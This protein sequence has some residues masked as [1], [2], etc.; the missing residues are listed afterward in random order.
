M[1][2][3]VSDSSLEVGVRLVLGLLVGALLH[4]AFSPAASAWP[5]PKGAHASV[6]GPPQEDGPIVVNARFELRDLND[7]DDAAERFEFGGTLELTWQ[8]ER[9]AFDPAVAGVDEKVYQGFFQFNEISPAWYPQIVLV[10]ESGMFE[11]HGIVLKVAPDGT[12]RLVQIVDAAAESDL[13]LRRYPFDEHRLEATFEVLDSSPAEVLL[14]TDQPREG[15]E[16]HGV[17]IPQWEVREITAAAANDGGQST[18]VLSIDA[19]RNPF[20]VVRLVVIPLLLIVVLSWSV[21]WMGGSSLGDRLGISFIGILTA[22]AYQIVVSDIQPDIAYMTLMHGFLNL[23]LFLMCATV[24]VNL[25][26]GSLERRGNDV[27][28]RL[29]DRRCRWVFPSLYFGLTIVMAIVTFTFF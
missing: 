5:P 4:A 26:V 11:T 15:P 9:Q 3:F 18:F 29:V 12:S 10:N 21:F 7:I 24:V 28:A 16:E 20:F 25:V 22:V 2:H 1:R 23:S 14:R 17:T 27:R 8:D 13:D 6:L 19:K